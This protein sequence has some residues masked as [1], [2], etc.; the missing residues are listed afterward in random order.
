MYVG[1]YVCTCMHAH[2]YVYI[3]CFLV[4]CYAFSTKKNNNPIYRKNTFKEIPVNLSL[5][6]FTSVALFNYKSITKT[7][8]SKA[9]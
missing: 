1:M 3:V 7:P 2:V 4:S 6:V 8:F 9:L 5:I